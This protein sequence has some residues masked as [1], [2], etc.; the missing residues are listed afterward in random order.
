M[1][2]TAINYYFQMDRQIKLKSK[3]INESK[4]AIDNFINLFLKLSILTF[5]Y[6]YL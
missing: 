6:M 3:E 5:N 1:I 2:V 4:K